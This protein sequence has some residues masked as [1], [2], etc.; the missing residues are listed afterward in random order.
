MMQD[1]RAPLVAFIVG[2]SATAR[3]SAAAASDRSDNKTVPAEKARRQNFQWSLAC[4]VVLSVLAFWAGLEP[5]GLTQQ[6]GRAPVR[7]AMLLCRSIVYASARRGLGM[8]IM[9]EA[10]LETA[11]Y[12]A[13]GVTD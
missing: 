10:L 12:A 11:L 1:C 5:S 7:G 4:L 9:S 2:V 13:Q 3:F 6:C 8:V